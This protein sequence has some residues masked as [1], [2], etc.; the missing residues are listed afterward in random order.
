VRHEGHIRAG[1]VDMDVTFLDADHDL[2]DA[3]DAVYRDKYRRY[4]PA[5]LDR[6][7]SPKARSTTIQLVPR[8]TSPRGRHLALKDCHCQISS[9]GLL[10]LDSL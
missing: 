8:S 3:L 1:G 9:A 7:T 10:L 6:I 2:N 5:T 4:S